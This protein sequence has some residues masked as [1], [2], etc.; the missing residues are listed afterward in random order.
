MASV[1]PIA[2]H[3]PGRKSTQHRESVSCLQ[4]IGQESVSIHITVFIS[5]TLK[6]LLMHVKQQAFQ[7]Q[8]IPEPVSLPESKKPRKI[9]AALGHWDNQIYVESINFLWSKLKMWVSSSL[10]SKAHT[11]FLPQSDAGRKS[12]SL[13]SC[14]YLAMEKKVL[15]NWSLYVREKSS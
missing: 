15:Q 6:L 3:I 2:E 9:T 4:D 5:R 11:I 12:V 7:P 14:L 1:P 8:N 10:T 13:G